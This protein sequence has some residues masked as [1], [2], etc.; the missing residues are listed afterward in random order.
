[1]GRR[2][3]FGR[4]KMAK[5]DP[6]IGLA[7]DPIVDWARGVWDK[8]VLDTTLQEAW[9]DAVRSVGLAKRPFQEVKGPCGAA[10]ASAGRLGWSFPHFKFFKTRLGELLDLERV[11]PAVVHQYAERD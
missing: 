3:A 11:C 5:Y 1:M 9:R 7:I 4:L 2:S 8:P 6:T 10:T